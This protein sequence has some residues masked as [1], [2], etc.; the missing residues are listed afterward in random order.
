MKRN[1]LENHPKM[2]KEKNTAFFQPKW[3]YHFQKPNY[4]N[5]RTE[6][7]NIFENCGEGIIYSNLDTIFIL[8]LGLLSVNIPT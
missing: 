1:I 4:H 3:N 8:F 6:V 7:W 2:E 5:Q